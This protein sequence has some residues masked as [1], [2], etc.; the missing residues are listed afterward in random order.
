MTHLNPESLRFRLALWATVLLCCIQLFLGGAFYKFTSVW[1]EQQLDQTLSTTA[2][3]VAAT[4]QD[5]DL[6]STSD[7]AVHLNS[8]DQAT[9]AFLQDQ[10]FSMRLLDQRT[11]EILETTAAYALP[12]TAEARTSVA[13]Y[14]TLSVTGQSSPVRVYTLPL[15]KSGYLALQV[16]QSLR[17]IGETQAQIL[18]ILLAMLIVTALL[19]L[20]TGIFLADRALIP[21][22]AITRTARQI[23]E[24]DLKQ[25]IVLPLPADELGELAQTFNSM[26]DRIEGAFLRQSR[27]TSDAAHELRTPLSIMKTGVEVVLEQ[28]RT[29][30]QYRAALE[31][32]EEEVQRLTHLTTSLLSLARADSPTL[33]LNR[34]SID[35][36]IMVHTVLDQLAPVAEQKG[37]T[38]GRRIVPQL[39]FCGDEDRL[40]QLMLNLV[41]NAIKYTPEDG[42]ITVTAAQSGSSV[43]I[44]VADTGPGIPAEHL[45]H[46]FDRFYRVDKSRNRDQGGFGLGLAI[47]QQ[48]V[49]LHKG[50]IKVSSQAEVGTQFTVRLP[51][52]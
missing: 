29:P 7:L 12:V 3:Q 51:I 11:G 37:V 21:V 52:S 9:N 10:L 4:L 5:D 16:T 20:V 30:I 33:V 14:Q 47:A 6:A 28:E 46:I 31:T 13:T 34:E 2:A 23:G 43:S 42:R 24:H 44:T 22:K 48:I 35:L 45:N 15:V 39:P 17:D 27:F 49:Q 38:I 8:A 18:K 50:E 32:I 1:L 26:L 36:S 41:Q 40:I 25:R 19:A